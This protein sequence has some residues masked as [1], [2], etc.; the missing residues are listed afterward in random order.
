MSILDK[1]ILII[2]N[3]SGKCLI[4]ESIYHPDYFLDYKPLSKLGRGIRRLWHILG[5]PKFCNNFVSF[6][7]E[8]LAK[9]DVIILFQCMYAADM[10]Q[11]IRQ[12]NSHARLIYWLWNSY[13]GFTVSP[14]YNDKKIFNEI[15]S[16]QFQRKFNFEIWSFDHMDCKRFNLK[17]NNTFCVKLKRVKSKGVLYDVMFFG[18]DKDRL[19]VLKEL[20]KTFQE[21]GISYDIKVIP[22]K[23]KS[24]PKEDNL[25]LSKLFLPYPKF[26]EKEMESR[27]FLEIVQNGQ[28]DITWRAMEAQFYEKKLITN[29]TGIKQYPFYNP[30]NIFILGEDSFDNLASFISAPYENLNPNLIRKFQFDGWLENFF[31]N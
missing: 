31:D 23:R 2:G 22:D 28:A 3:D 16:K 19:H 30:H 12:Y 24:Y 14:L 8:E 29:C 20:A 1:K 18:I 10:I 26:V 25:Y 17:F 9:Y 13:K 6:S 27:C 7:V 11:L 5:V 4:Q 15:C 21:Y